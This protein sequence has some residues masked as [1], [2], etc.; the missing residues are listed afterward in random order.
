MADT[1][2]P[3]PE[4]EAAAK[5]EAMQVRYWLGEVD[6]ALKREKRY[7]K[8]AREFIDIYEGEV[9]PAY[10]ILYSNTE[11][12]SPAIYNSNPI[13]DTRPKLKHEEPA[14]LAAS[15]LVNAYLLQFIDSGDA[16][17]CSYAEACRQALIQGL[18]PGRGLQRFHY[19]ADVERSAK[20][21]PERV[22]DE[23]VYGEALDWDKVLF[24][25]AKTWV[26]VPWV[27]FV[28][29]FTLESATEELGAEA[30]AKLAYALKEEDD[31]ENA[32]RKDSEGAEETAT[33]YEIWFKAKR[34]RYFVAQ[35]C[36]TWLKPPEPDP[37]A[38]QAFY[39]MQEPLQF[40]QRV[41][42]F[43]PV[44]LY[45]LYRKQAREL[46]RIT[47]RITALIE[48]MKVRGFYDAGVEG[49]DKVLNSEDNTLIAL[50]MLAQM[51]QGGKVENAIWLVP[52]EKY[53]L[54]LQQLIQQRQAIK[55]VI[56]EIMGIAD[57]MR[58][59]S[60]ASETLGAQEI[61]NKW[62]V[63][64][65]K[66]AQNRMA[67]FIR[68]G[69]RIAAEMAFT[70]MAPETLRQLTGSTLPAAAKLA[71]MEAQVKQAQTMGG[72]VPPEVQAQLALPA[73]EECLDV[74]RDD[75]ARKFVIDI[76]TNSSIDAEATED[77]EAVSEFMGGFSQVLQGIGPLV[78]QGFLP[79]EAAKM[80]ILAITKK[81]RLGRELE[82]N[83]RKMQQPP[84]QANGKEQEAAA[85]ERQAL[86][87][88]QAKLA[89]DRMKFQL[90]QMK[91]KIEQTKLGMQQEMDAERQKMEIEK[92]I[93]ELE[94][95]V[96]QGQMDAE[97]SSMQLQSETQRA[98]FG[99]DQK[100][101]AIKQAEAQAA[102][103]AQLREAKFDSK[104]AVAAQRAKANGSKQPRR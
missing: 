103:S 27:G 6:K 24:G 76:E 47:D 19:R 70:K 88:D 14:A 82:E 17:Y 87:Q 50:Q 63:L 41:S 33:V 40:F 43:L 39:P 91:A 84:P 9:E 38:L 52:I 51:G 98:G 83:L 48:G 97:R 45:R 29:N 21:E 95:L 86:M 23:T 53:I 101:Q 1:P 74:L 26:A 59:A 90:E 62:G 67:A 30:A 100:A 71:Q 75:I 72:Q 89:Q 2:K 96:Q 92:L 93:M 54:V 99:L 80:I 64:R 8:E 12:L 102:G 11:T 65:L 4:A 22:R 61:K 42:A 7:R 78:E 10:N 69:L 3:L 16:R 104:Q 56:F 31:G 66:Q 36:K 57:I 77:K 32:A 44:P 13:P 79:F 18:V 49:L 58:G 28:H 55:Q 60:V 34:E 25:Y 20:G 15:G 68:D 46:N 73:F 37:Y 85:K 5:G 81:F 94:K 35:S